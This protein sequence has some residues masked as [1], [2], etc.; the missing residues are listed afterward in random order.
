MLT[1]EMPQMKVRLSPELKEW[2]ARQ[3][4]CNRRS[5]NAEIVLRLEMSQAKENASLAATGEALLKQ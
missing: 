1:R 2:L 3:A 5:I 4:I